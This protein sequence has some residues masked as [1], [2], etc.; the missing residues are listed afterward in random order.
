MTYEDRMEHLLESEREVTRLVFALAGYLVHDV[1]PFM[2]LD[3]LEVIDSNRIA[4]L[5]EY[6]EE[7]IDCLVVS[8]LL[9]MP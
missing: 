5:V 1:I 2:L 7:Y 9:E 3:S 8:L 4:E 6:F